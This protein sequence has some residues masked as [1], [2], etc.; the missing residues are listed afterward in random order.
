[1]LSATPGP[2][3]FTGHMRW[4]PVA[5][6]I[7]GML[8]LIWIGWLI[9]QPLRVPEELPD[10]SAVR[11][12]LEIVQ[13]D[14]ADT[15]S[16]FKLRRDVQYLFSDDHRA[17][18]AYRVRS[19]V[20]L[21]SGDPVGPDESVPG[22]IA[23]AARLAERQGLRLAVLGAGQALADLYRDAGLRRVY[24]GDE[25]VVDT[26]AF[27]LEGRRIRKVRQS[28]NR[29]EAA[30]YRLSVRTLAEVSQAELDAFA[31]VSEAW[32]G[33]DCERGFSMAL[34]E[35]GGRHQADTVVAVAHDG[36]GTIRGFLHFA[37][38]YG[39]AAVSLASMRRERDTPN[40]FTEFM[41]ARTIE[42]LRMRGICEVSLN[43]VVFGRWMRAPRG[44]IEAILGRVVAS[45]TARATQVASL[46]RFSAK[47]MPEWR[48]RDLWFEGMMGLPAAALASLRAEGQ[49]PAIG[50]GARSRPSAKEVD[51]GDR[52]GSHA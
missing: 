18:V 40:G 44:R 1:M 10:E 20:L 50:A 9:S 41:I 24:L 19:G 30:G 32:L 27:T 12:G 14:G 45:S 37:P 21:V 28:V 29:L 49:L 48:R 11:R 51:V 17:F 47:F 7:V 52:V 23:D 15:L 38:C 33:D 3:G 39:A 4:L 16:F 35:L 25:A 5:V 42:A 43:F 22:L 34:D 8:G 13:A 31:R 36:S 6:G 46:Y 2:I 26:A